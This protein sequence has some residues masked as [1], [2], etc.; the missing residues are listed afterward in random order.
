MAFCGTSTGSS[1]YERYEAASSTLASTEPNRV[2]SEV[3]MGSWGTGLTQHDAVIE[4]LNGWFEDPL[5]ADDIATFAA[6]VGTLAW[7][8]PVLGF[9]NTEGWVEKRA[10]LSAESPETDAVRKALDYVL[11]A[12]RQPTTADDIL[13]ACGAS[14]RGVRQGALLETS[15][16]KACIEAVLAKA[17]DAL[18]A[19]EAN[20][21]QAADLAGV[22]LLLVAEESPDAARVLKWRQA[23]DALHESMGD[24]FDAFADRVRPAFFILAG[25]ETWKDAENESNKTSLRERRKATITQRVGEEARERLQATHGKGLLPAV[26][27]AVLTK[28]CEATRP[29]VMQALREL[30]KTKRIVKRANRYHLPG[31]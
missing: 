21:F 28:D 16:G 10:A 1:L 7:L 15:E 5:Q 20:G 17:Y 23:F 3:K 2:E 19:T 8:S 25:S 27:V 18:D 4:A 13:S 31:R 29:Q 22:N 24:D 12:A 14:D 30:E 26:M 6:R 9:K 11:D